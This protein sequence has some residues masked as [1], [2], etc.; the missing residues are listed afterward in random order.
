M[1]N[2]NLNSLSFV[3]TKKC[4]LKCEMCTR[5]A[6][7]DRNSMMSVSFIENIVDQALSFSQLKKVNLTGGEAFLHPEME[8]IIK[9]ITNRKIDIRINTNGLFFTDSN[10]RM[11]NRYDVKLF[12]VSLDSSNSEIH[13]NIRGIKGCYEKTIENLKKIKCEGYCYFVKATANTKNVDTLFELMKV[14]EDLGAYGYS[15]GRTIPVGRAQNSTL[16]N[17]DFWE[18]YSKACYEC[19]KYAIT[20]KMKFLIDDP[21]RHYFDFRIKKILEEHPAIDISKASS[22]CSA[23]KNFLYILPNGDIL[24]CPALT[25]VI[26]NVN[27]TKLEELWK[28]SEILNQIRNR[29]NLKG[30]C[31]HC[32]YKKICGG[33]RAHAYAT[34]NDV[35]ETDDLC[36]QNYLEGILSLCK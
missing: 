26:G 33:C 30:L 6:G 32:G 12:T 36:P 19:S 28:N 16:C 1:E 8:E 35:L 2:N 4:N 22:G 27:N 9:A 13:D 18:R 7:I 11:L 15:I 21:L 14:V 31:G 23:G 3:I 24:A 5:D 25:K 10:I 20:S 34:H 17:V 29:D